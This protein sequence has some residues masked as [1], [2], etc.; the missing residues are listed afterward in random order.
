[1]GMPASEFG[2]FKI[3]SDKDLRGFGASNTVS[4]PTTAM[5]PDDAGYDTQWY[6]NNPDA[7]LGGIDINIETVW[8]EYSGLGVTLGIID[9]G[10]DYAH[11]DIAENYDATIDYD[12][13]DGILGL[14]A[15]DPISDG[16]DD[17]HGT[18]V[19]GVMAGSLGGGDIVGVA[20]GASLAMFRMGFGFEA[21]ASQTEAVLNQMG[22]VDVVNNSWTYG[23]AFT[24]NKNEL[25]SAEF[26]D[27]ITD[28]VDAGREE[29]GTVIVFA[30]GNY[31]ES[32]DSSNYHSFS[33]THETISVGSVG[34]YGSASSFTSAG[35]SILLAAPGENIVT[36]D[37]S[38]Q[39]G[40]SV[41][42]YFDSFS[43]TSAAAPIVSGVAA[44]ML[45][46]NPDLGYR[47]VQ[48]ILAYS[49]SNPTGNVWTSNAAGN[50]NGGGLTFT[51]A[52]GFGIVDAYAAVRL[53]ESWGDADSDIANYSGNFSDYTVTISAGALTVTDSDGN[54]ETPKSVKTLRFDD[55]DYTISDNGTDT[56]L[57]YTDG[58]DTTVT[59]IRGLVTK[60]S[61]TYDNLVQSLSHD[62]PYINPGPPQF[63]KM[64]R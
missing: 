16:L 51:D 25:K 39:G 8:D 24:D 19:A 3:L 31:G 2:D 57:T 46:A 34:L 9:D 50:A 45:E 38:G 32:G 1:M 61:A 30:A 7:S 40:F 42:D 20:H 13:L 6:F 36:T 43:G 4:G 53:A 62:G 5:V 22:S 27:A 60:H 14:G 49:A 11:A 26:F 17:F 21:S 48:E 44:L 10:I 64:R 33:S 56:T 58:T 28:A 23:E 37:L 41:G 35:S 47:D 59:T 12:A 63:Q 15:V 29:L 54:A 55:G 18:A 52:Y